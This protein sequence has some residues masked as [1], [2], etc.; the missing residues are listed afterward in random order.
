MKRLTIATA[1]ALTFAFS[2][3]VLAQSRDDGAVG[4]PLQLDG[5]PSLG[6]DSRGI[7][8]GSEA[9]RPSVG[10]SSE[11]S[12][13]GI[14][15]AGETKVRERS[16]THIGRSFRPKHR[17]A[18]HRRGHHLFAFRMPRHRFVIHR[19]GRRFVAFN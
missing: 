12:Q 13:T 10:A 5:G 6:S 7:G 3:S 1:A 15:K 18:I 17:F 2:Q 14:E 11:K 19:H 4:K 9:A 16:R 8:A